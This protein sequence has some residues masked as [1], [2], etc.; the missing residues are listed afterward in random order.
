M[1]VLGLDPTPLTPSL[2]HTKRWWPS[3]RALESQFWVW[4]P[5]PPPEWWCIWVVARKLGV[6]W[7][8][9]LWYYTS[10]TVYVL[11]FCYERSH[12]GE[13]RISCILLFCMIVCSSFLHSTYVTWN[14]VVIAWR[15]G[16]MPVVVFRGSVMRWDRG[17]NWVCQGVGT[18]SEGVLLGSTPDWMIALVS[19]LSKGTTNLCQFFPHQAWP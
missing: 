12:T 2:C 3:R 7:G 18:G 14:H 17:R 10:Y 13:P 4:T 1:S 5:V 16:S 19:S 15:P 6:L 11:P 9:F 8:V